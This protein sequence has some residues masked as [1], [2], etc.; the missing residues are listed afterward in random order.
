MKLENK[1]VQLI[2]DN[3]K[4]SALVSLVE[5]TT[6]FETV[7][8]IGDVIYGFDERDKDT[9]AYD[10]KD[11]LNACINVRSE[12]VSRLYDAY[13]KENDG[14][15]PI[16]AQH[17]K[18]LFT[19]NEWQELFD[20]AKDDS[21][22]R[23]FADDSVALRIFNIHKINVNTKLVDFLN[24]FEYRQVKSEIW[25][26]EFE[27]T[28][29][30]NWQINGTQVEY[31]TWLKMNKD[32]QQS[33]SQAIATKNTLVAMNSTVNNFI[34]TWGDRYPIVSNRVNL[35]SKTSKGAA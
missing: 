2:V 28:M 27:A 6:D 1:E 23:L 17:V 21:L 24:D 33:Y 11:L 5:D 10:L 31:D 32:D 30:G 18:E 7:T 25:N 8:K 14:G 13:L 20:C 34:D 22:T 12:N 16:L 3:A 9:C 4:D 15:I 29:G 26:D 35:L 19:L